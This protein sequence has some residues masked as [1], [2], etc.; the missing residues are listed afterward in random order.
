MEKSWTDKH[1][2]FIV[3][4][5]ADDLNHDYRVGDWSNLRE[6]IDAFLVP[7]PA[8]EYGRVAETF[9]PDQ[10]M[11]SDEQL[12]EIQEDVR[13]ILEFFVAPSDGTR[14][15]RYVRVNLSYIAHRFSDEAARV[16]MA[17]G[18]K[19]DCVLGL[20]LRLLQQGRTAPITRCPAPSAGKNTT[21]GKIFYRKGKQKYCSR[22]CTNRQMSRTKREKDAK[23]EVE[24]DRFSRKKTQSRKKGAKTSGRKQSK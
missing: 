1:I 20:L 4:F 17:R 13:E 19:R 18:P 12:R 14:P 2:E 6:D 22:L 10:K 5:A 15:G 16:T 23:A 24:K 3:R 9:S 21:C 11:L 7:D 8:P